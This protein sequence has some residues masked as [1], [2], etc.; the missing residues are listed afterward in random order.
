MRR[1]LAALIGC[2]LAPLLFAQEV[3]FPDGTTPSNP[4]GG[5]MILR[6]GNHTTWALGGGVFPRAVKVVTQTAEGKE[7]ARFRMPSVFQDP[8]TPPLPTA[9]PAWLQVE[10][11]DAYSLIFVEG[12]QV[13]QHGRSRHMESP[14]L[15]PGRRISCAY[16]RSTPLAKAY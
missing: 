3:V 2:L 9:G 11:P 13:R 4:P 10:L 5:L 14:L 15:R 6:T 7:I 12:E 1:V 8:Y 16:A